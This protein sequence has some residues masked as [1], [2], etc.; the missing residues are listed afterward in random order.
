MELVKEIKLVRG[1]VDKMKVKL[2][3]LEM[4]IEKSFTLIFYVK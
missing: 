2:N 3:A 1:I 4:K